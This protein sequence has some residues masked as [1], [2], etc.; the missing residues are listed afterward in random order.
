MIN[1]Q[2]TIG[3]FIDIMANNENVFIFTA[4]IRGLHV[5]QRYWMHTEQESLTCSYEHQ[6]P[7]DMLAIKTTT[8][9]G[10][11]VGHLPQEISRV[12]KFLLDRGATITAELTSSQ[13]R[14]SPLVQRGLEIAC[15]TV[16]N[17]MLIDRHM[18]LVKAL[19]TEPKD[20]QIMGSFL[21]KV[22]RPLSDMPAKKKKS[23]PVDVLPNRKD[24]RSGNIKTMFANIQRR[25][26]MECQNQGSSKDIIEIDG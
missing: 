23:V 22:P 24:E 26:D 8:A 1:K 5:Y 21:T 14:R 15:K 12:T 6:N 25:Q 11:A 10:N 19:Y 9:N 2:Y 18:D 17:H 16:R 20:E 3:E 4:A 7:Y 13:Y